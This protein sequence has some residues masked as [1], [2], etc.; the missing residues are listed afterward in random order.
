M[1]YLIA[2]II[3]VIPALII[4]W[5]MISVVSAQRQ[6]NEILHHILDE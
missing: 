1:T 4:I 3:Y 2:S 5:F 6:R